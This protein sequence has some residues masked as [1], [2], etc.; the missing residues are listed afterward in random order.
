MPREKL[1]KNK[2]NMKLYGYILKFI[3]LMQK[4]TKKMWLNLTVF[5][6]LGVETRAIKV[7]S[8]YPYYFVDI[9]NFIFIFV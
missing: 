2:I 7:Y 4:Y 9:Q 8:Q 5:H 1:V 3:I 6:M